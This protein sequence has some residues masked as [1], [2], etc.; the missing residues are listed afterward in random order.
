MGA[1]MHV[2]HGVASPSTCISLDIWLQE[3]LKWCILAY[4]CGYA[5]DDVMLKLTEACDTSSSKL[6]ASL[7]VGCTEGVC[8]TWLTI[9]Q[10]GK[11]NI[12]RW[13]ARAPPICVASGDSTVHFCLHLQ[14]PSS[15]CKVASCPAAIAYACKMS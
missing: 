6:P 12:N 1:H 10:T 11:G 5:E 2:Y 8:I 15:R 3:F 14:A 13:S 4:E 7:V 9:E